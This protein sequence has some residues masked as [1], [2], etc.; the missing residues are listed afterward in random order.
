MAEPAG[1]CFG[2]KKPVRVDGNVVGKQRPGNLVSLH[3]QCVVHRAKPFQQ[4]VHCCWTTECMVTEGF[5]VKE[6][7]VLGVVVEVE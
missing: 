2:S 1:C 7:L 3:C 6:L 4:T 5:K